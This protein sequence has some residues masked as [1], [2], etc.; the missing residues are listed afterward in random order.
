MFNFALGWFPFFWFL[1]VTAVWDE[2][3]WWKTPRAINTR[4]RLD[5]GCYADEVIQLKYGGRTKS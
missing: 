2:W 5:C 3:E 4:R 1:L